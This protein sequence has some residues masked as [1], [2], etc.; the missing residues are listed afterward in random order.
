MPRRLTWRQSLET[1]TARGLEAQRL[2]KNSQDAPLEL[3][4][5]QCPSSIQCGYSKWGSLRKERGGMDAGFVVYLTS[6]T[7]HPEGCYKTVR[8]QS[9]HIFRGWWKCHVLIK[10]VVSQVNSWSLNNMKFRGTESPPPDPCSQKS[11]YLILWSALCSLNFVSRSQS[12][13]DCVVL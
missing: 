6:F 7:H 1:R 11:K 12:T 4:L 10:D 5:K 13:A 3:P 9:V 2:V 8:A